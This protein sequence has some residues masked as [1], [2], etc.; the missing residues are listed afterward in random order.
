MICLAVSKYFYLYISFYIVISVN[1]PFHLHWLSPCSLC[2]ACGVVR[3]PVIVC[4]LY[5]NRSEIDERF[6]TIQF[7]I[8]CSSS[9]RGIIHSQ[10]SVYAF[11]L[12]SNT[13]LHKSYWK[14]ELRLF[15]SSGTELIWENITWKSLLFLSDEGH[16]GALYSMW[17]QTHSA[18]LFPDQNDP[19]FTDSI[20]KD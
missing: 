18:S 7:T 12:S 11:I 10:H 3:K 14:V 8:C 17:C 15:L 6:W 19:Y 13:S 16:R 20:S 2:W 5:I 9:E 4:R 1:L